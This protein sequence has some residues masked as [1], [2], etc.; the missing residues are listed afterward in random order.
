MLELQWLSWYPSWISMSIFANVMTDYLEMLM[1]N[2][3]VQSL[4]CQIE[5]LSSAVAIV[6]TAK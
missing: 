3:L 2:Y 6:C 1:P 5:K 4:Q